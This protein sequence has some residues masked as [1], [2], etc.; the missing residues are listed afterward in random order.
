MPLFKNAH[1][2]VCGKEFAEGDDVVYCPECGTPHH[3]DCMLQHGHC[4]NEQL[5]AQG[6]NYF[7]EHKAERVD[8]IVGEAK[9]AYKKQQE[10][11][12]PDAA[13]DGMPETPFGMFTP[14]TF[15][16]AYDNDPET[17]DGEK[18]ADIATVVGTNVPRFIT[19]FKR[20]EA[21]KSKL[22][23]NWGAFLFGPLY[24]LYRKMFREGMLLMALN[25]A[26]NAVSALLI[27]KMAPLTV[28]AINKYAETMAK[29]TPKIEDLNAFYAQL[30]SIAD[31]RQYM[32]VN[33]LSVLAMVLISVIFAVLADY[34]Y[35]RTVLRT[36]KAVTA[37]LSQ[38]AEFKASA[39]DNS[40][41]NFSQEQMKRMY[42]ARR[43]G[44]SF[45]LPTV[46]ML[47]LYVLNMLI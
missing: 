18:M 30:G 36:V 4:A 6:Y 9:A 16:N 47:L 13:D 39:S 44:T 1:C 31:F 7:E 11:E 34:L 5:H 45:L 37:Q 10:A 42:L 27:Q 32:L 23:W 26:I 19:V 22:S 17:I 38:G 8:N 43:G 24:F 21:K 14:P 2:P 25:M 35:K 12:A 41:V 20:Q 29:S 46:A 15:R 3:R 28:A 33:T 40:P